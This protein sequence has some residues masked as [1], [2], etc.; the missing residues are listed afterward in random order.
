MNTI[1]VYYS[2]K[3]SNEFLAQKI[4]GRLSCDIEAVRPRVDAFG[5]IL[6][7]INPGIRP[8]KH[9]I[10]KYDRVILVGPIFMGRFI[11]PLKG[12]LKKHPVISRRHLLLT[13]FRKYPESCQYLSCLQNIVRVNGKLILEILHLAVLIR[14]DKF[15]LS[16]GDQGN[17]DKLPVG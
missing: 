2:R 8:M 10:E 13:R 7:N 14:P 11:T 1:V 3:G 4:A 17:L 6:M 9:K 12:F 16:G 5:T 15:L